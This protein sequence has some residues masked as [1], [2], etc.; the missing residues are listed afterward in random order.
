MKYAKLETSTL[1]NMVNKLQ[2]LNLEEWLYIQHLR[3]PGK[4][5]L[6]FIKSS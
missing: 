4:A 1:V 6:H 3:Y 2:D 5:G